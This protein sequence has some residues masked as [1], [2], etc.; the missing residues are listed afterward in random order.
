MCSSDLLLSLL[1]PEM[2]TDGP[3]APPRPIP[4]ALDFFAGTLAGTSSPLARGWELTRL[5]G[6]ASLLCGHPFDTSTSACPGEEGVPDEE[7][8]RRR[9]D[10][11][12]A[13]S[14]SGCSARRKMGGTGTRCMRLGVSCRQ[15]RCVWELGSGGES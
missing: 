3:A 12:R 5:A 13:Q 6:V 7:C 8:A 10:A 1:P 11:S 14:R 15:R 4:P 9:A 2:E